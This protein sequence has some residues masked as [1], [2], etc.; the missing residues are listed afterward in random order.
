VSIAAE[1]LRSIAV[2]SHDLS[3]EAF[4][5]ARA[6]IIEKSFPKDAYICHR[7]DK[8]DA[9]T[10]IAAGLVKMSSVSRAGKAVVY[11]GLTT[12]MWF[13]EGTLLKDEERRYDLVALR[14]TR[15][16]MMNKPTFFWLFETSAAFN[17]FLVRQ[18]NER[19]GQFI[20][21]VEHDRLLDANGRVARAIA[22]LL[23]PALNP[24]AG[25][26]LEINQEELGLVAGLS[27]QAANRALK[28]LEA[29]GLI[30][31]EAEG[32]RVLD[33]KRLRCFGD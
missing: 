19:I 4:E 11:A 30:R 23:N 31:V 17:R 24:G 22:A 14:D 27:R 2:W 28:A 3:E 20:A 29:T 25:A 15:L 32:V 6:G 13:G 16:A 33:M 18:F 8:L 21:Q 10:G 9:W 5:R 1:R 7:G 26:Y 12:N